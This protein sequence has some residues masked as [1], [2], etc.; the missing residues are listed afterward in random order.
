MN[1]NPSIKEPSTTPKES[2]KT[3]DTTLVVPGGDDIER[4]PMT[5]AELKRLGD[6]E[7]LVG[8]G[9]CN[10]M[11]TGAA[12]AEIHHDGLYRKEYISF[13]DYLSRKWGLGKSH[14]YRLINAANV[15]KVLADEDTVQPSNEAQ[16]RPLTA[17]EIKNVP[18][19]WKLAIEKADGK[20]VTEEMVK[21]AVREVTGKKEGKPKARKL[22][23]KKVAKEAT[24]F[25][26][27]LRATSELLERTRSVEGAANF[28]FNIEPFLK[29]LAKANNGK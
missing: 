12:L 11:E 4:E 9:L 20:P 2:T 8:K 18:K 16:V 25:L 13:D 26:R 6:L 19:I 28:M 14:G 29:M 1:K 10:F 3:I 15:A 22:S 7:K 21:K 17:V 24:F 23:W 27:D 5:D